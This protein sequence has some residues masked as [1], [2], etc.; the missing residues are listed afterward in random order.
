MSECVSLHRGLMLS[1]TIA[2]ADALDLG[3]VLSFSVELIG[4][5]GVHDE[6]VYSSSFF[7]QN[8]P[9]SLRI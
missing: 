5:G 7:P 1:L 9:T 8:S 3:Q 4:A 6:R 2:G